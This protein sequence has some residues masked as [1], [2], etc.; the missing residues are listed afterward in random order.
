M[1]KIVLSKKEKLVLKNT[2]D[3]YVD[4]EVL[5][6]EELYIVLKYLEKIGLVQVR[7]YNGELSAA[8]L[9]DFGKKYKL[10][11]PKLRNGITDTN[12]WVISMIITVLLAITTIIIQLLCKS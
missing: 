5:P 3:D 6:K 9:T 12:K 2:F 10:E 4:N 7:E 11:N 8:R 1:E